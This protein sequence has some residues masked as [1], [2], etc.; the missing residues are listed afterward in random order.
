MHVLVGWTTYQ[1]FNLLIGLSI[2]PS[3]L[4]Y[5]LATM[6]A[7]L[8]YL[9]LNHL[10]VGGALMIARQISWRDSGI[11]E[12][13]SLSIDLAMLMM[14]IMVAILVEASLW[15]IAPA[16]APLYLIYRAL[17]IPKLKRQASSDPKTGL[18][19]AE[20]FRK[21]L[22]TELYRAQRFSR[23]LVVVMADLDL[24]RNINN[25]YGHLAG[26]A[27]LTGV[28]TVLKAN[29]REFD[30]VA[31]FGGEEF[32][33]LMPETTVEQAY[34]R[35]EAIRRQ[36]EDT[37]FIAPLTNHKIRATMSFGIT[38]LAEDDKTTIDIVHRAD[39]AVYAAKIRGRNQTCRSD[40]PADSSISLEE[41][42]RV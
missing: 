20:Y 13:E 34:P 39:L 19:N 9:T 16:L 40:Y 30:T 17:T 37:S 28:A 26:D 41:R 42:I 25:V 32:S 2:Q 12:R 35:I 22:E 21:T 33:I 36:I 31:R 10:T 23:P 15:L 14:G 27:V 4:L 8:A 11:F 29:L 6:G 24:L 5:L 1:L 7:A 38:G 18:W 3:G